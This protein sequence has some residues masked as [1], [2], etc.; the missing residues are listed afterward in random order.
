MMKVK[1]ERDIE[2]ISKFERQW[3]I[4]TSEEKFQI[5]PIARI[6][7]K[8]INVNNKKIETRKS[9]KLLGL[10]ISTTGL[11]SHI[12]LAIKKKEMAF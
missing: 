5:I 1:V 7:T 8:K 10:D 9:G 11:V 4:K 3:K 12:S 2:R 6:N